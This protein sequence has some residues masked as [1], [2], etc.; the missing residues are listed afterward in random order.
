MSQ[1]ILFRR[2]LYNSTQQENIDN[3]T[4]T[5]L[6]EPEIESVFDIN[7]ATVEDFFI[8][9]Q[10][11]YS[12]IP[13]YGE[14]NSHEYLIKES[15]KIVTLNQQNDAVQN[16]LDEIAE[17]RQQNLDLQQEKVDIITQLSANTNINNTTI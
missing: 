14:T 3:T 5:Q 16:L 17:L 13:Q 4:I 2:K 15:S 11:L 7:L 12:L 9:Y 10:N 6:T 1:N 8:I